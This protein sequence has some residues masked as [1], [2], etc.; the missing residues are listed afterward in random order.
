IVGDIRQGG[1]AVEARPE[2]YMPYE[3]HPG[4]STNMGLLVRTVG[5]PTALNETLRRLVHERSPDVPLRFTTMEASM[6]EVTSAPRFRTLLLAIFA[7]LAICLAM[8]GVYGVMAYVVSQRSSEIGL[9]M[10]LG[11]GSGNVL[12]MVLKQGLWLAGIGLVLGLA[13][14]A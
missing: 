3:Q 14:A 2:V 8:A 11:A 9:R 6:A 4:A 12:T 5:D 7:A 13:G 10:A 1:P